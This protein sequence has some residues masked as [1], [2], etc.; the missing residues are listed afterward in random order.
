MSVRRE[1]PVCLAIG[2][3]LTVVSFGSAELAGHFGAE[4]IAQVL[5]WPNAMLQSAAPCVPVDVGTRTICEG[6]PLNVLALVTSFPLS[7][8][9]YSVLVYF[10]RR[11]RR[12]LTCVGA[13]REG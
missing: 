8:A 12:H 5:F 7:V 1:V 11:W 2:V 9:L 3:L 6:T 10:V 13:D 4:T